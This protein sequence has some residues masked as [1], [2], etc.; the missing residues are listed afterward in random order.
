MENLTIT[1]NLIEKTLSFENNKINLE[2]SL[3]DVKKNKENKKE[4]C[5]EIIYDNNKVL[6][7]EACKIIRFTKENKLTEKL[8]IKVY[9]HDNDAVQII[10]KYSLKVIKN[11]QT[12]IE[13]LSLP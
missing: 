2:K 5:T 7:D 13:I 10:G 9:E 1:I 4:T 11:Y 3:T 12:P 8:Y 6:Y